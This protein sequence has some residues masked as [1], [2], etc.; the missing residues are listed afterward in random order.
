M[1]KDT[2]DPGVAWEKDWTE[3]AVEVEKAGADALECIQHAGVAAARSHL[4]FLPPDL[5]HDG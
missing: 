5:Q 2:V 4:R 3:Q 1:Y